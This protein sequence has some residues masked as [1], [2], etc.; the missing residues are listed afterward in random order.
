MT[1]PFWPK[2]GSTHGEHIKASHDSKTILG[3]DLFGTKVDIFG[4]PKK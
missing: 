4:N 1:N 3:T 2:P